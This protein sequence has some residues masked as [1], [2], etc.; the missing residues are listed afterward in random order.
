MFGGLMEITKECNDTFKYD[1][2]QNCWTTMDLVP[3]LGNPVYPPGIAGEE[4]TPN[5]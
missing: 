1:I 2:G 4:A 3:K 5:L